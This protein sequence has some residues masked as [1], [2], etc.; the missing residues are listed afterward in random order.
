M[1]AKKH[2]LIVSYLFPPVNAV[3]IQRPLRLAN[4]A[5]RAGHSV[6]VL[7]GSPASAGKFYA[8]DANLNK[9]IDGG[10]AVMRLGSFHPIAKL[11]S[12]RDDKRKS[13]GAIS[14]PQPGSHGA[15]KATGGRRETAPGL[16][17]RI[18]DAIQMFF[19]VPDRF[20]SWIIPGLLAA[21]RANA[22]RK[23]DCVYVTGPPWTPM[24]LSAA[25]AR[26]L[27]I[28]LTVD[29]RDP[30][31]LNPYGERRP[32]QRINGALESWVLAKADHVIVN[33]ETMARE[34]ASR[35]PA[36]RAKIEAIYNGVDASLL[37]QVESLKRSRSGKAGDAFVVCHSGTL[38]A[39]R[40]PVQL[41]RIMARI[42]AEWNRRPDIR[43]RFV[44]DIDAPQSLIQ[45]FSEA[46]VPE[47]LE[48]LG[49]VGRQE[50]Q[51]IQAESDCL[52][53]LQ[54][55]TKLQLPAKVFESA[56][57]GKPILCVAEGDSETARVIEA[58]HLG[59]LFPPDLGFESLWQ[60]LTGLAAD[61]RT[62]SPAPAGFL[63]EFDGS[64]LAGRMLETVLAGVHAGKSA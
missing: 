45:A 12:M 29:Y 17:A 58:H 2:I 37:S 30:W 16:L 32:F 39:E 1:N 11:I 42:G 60:F 15:Q 38:Y 57:M 20:T 3:G 61:P 19:R 54:P 24:V 23:I 47:K 25:I 44:G 62:E 59:R 7:S 28:P 63:R 21:L 26:L 64:I 55:G 50:A 51:M 40:M 4:S 36:L 34:F 22:R 18:R 53:I 27:R 52:M 8:I 41:A 6:S 14:S 9:E 43:F 10:V 35:F 5:I 46:G 49:R 31:T 48:I 33:T 56:L 13:Q